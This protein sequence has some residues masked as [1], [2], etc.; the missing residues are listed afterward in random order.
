MISNPTWTTGSTSTKAGDIPVLNSRPTLAETIGGW[1][2]R[3]G[4]GRMSFRID[5]GLYAVGSP[6]PDSPVLVTANYKLTFDALRRSIDG[7]STWILV[8]E[9]NGINVWCAAGEGTFGTA[10]LVNR[11]LATS[12]KQVVSHKI[13]IAPQLGAPGIC[14]REVAKQAG[15]RVVF[16]PVRASDI[17][18]FLDAGKRATPEMRQVT[19]DILE[20][21][22]LIPLELMQ[23]LK[24]LLTAVVLFVAASGFSRYGFSL[25]SMVT[26]GINSAL[27]VLAGGFG[28]AVMTPLLLPWIPG[29]AFASKGLR[30]GLILALMLTLF[31]VGGNAGRF[32]TAS[33]FFI[34]PAISSFL[35]MNFTGASTYTS[36]SGVKKEVRTAL[37]LQAAAGVAGILLWL[38]GRFVS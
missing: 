9:T 11:I 30:A 37:P 7:L 10:E 28:G 17:S 19:F 29:R 4:I 27:A 25:E 38:V 18:A 33:W 21:A 26:T 16:G 35:A 31:H 34:I 36:L 32:E 20:R 6:G 2:A 1:K 13:V 8:L 23:A 24:Y 12:L 3:W 15:F 14:A 5:P 22:V